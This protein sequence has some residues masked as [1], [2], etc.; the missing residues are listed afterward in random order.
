[1]EA[2]EDGERFNDKFGEDQFFEARQSFTMASQSL[3]FRR[4]G[5]NEASIEMVEWASWD[6][7]D[8]MPL[9]YPLG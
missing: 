2:S 3:D 8:A 5:L 7:G 6:F 4:P 1:M 9:G